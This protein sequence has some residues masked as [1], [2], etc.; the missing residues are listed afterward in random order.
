MQHEDI[1]ISDP[2][3]HLGPTAT[4]ILEAAKRVLFRDGFRSLTFESIAREAG[5]N[6]ALIRYHFGSKA[7]LIAALV[8]SVLYLESVEFI[9]AVSAAPAGPERIQALLDLHAVSAHDLQAYRMFFELIPDILRD[10]DLLARFRMLF[11]WYR[12]LDAWGLAPSSDPRW[13]QRLMPLAML[14]VAIADG[15]ALQV[16]ADPEI[17]TDAA[18]AVWRIMVGR[19]LA[20]LGIAS[21]EIA[22]AARLG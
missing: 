3:P 19:H 8:D 11:E 5:E 1:P 21:A 15:L 13:A 12:K 18:F 9:E 22:E 16:Q 7:G 2:A 17:S 20:D 4:R 10:E 6:Q 14:T